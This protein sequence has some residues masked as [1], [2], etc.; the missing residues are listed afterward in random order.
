MT[1]NQKNQPE[2]DTDKQEQY[3][4][5][6]ESRVIDHIQSRTVKQHAAFF[7]S[8][9]QS[10]MSLLDCGC[11]PGTITLGLAKIVAPGHV[12]GIDLDKGQVNL[13]KAHAADQGISNISF[14]VANVYELPFEDSSFE[15]AFAHTLVQHLND[16][17]KGVKEIHRV[18]KPGGVMGI[19]DDDHG[20]MIRVPSN[21][22][23][24]QGYELFKRTWKHDGGDPLFGRRQREILRKAGFVNITATASCENYGTA[25]ATRSFGE[26]AAGFIDSFAKIAIQLGWTDKETIEQI[27]QEWRTWGENPDAF[28]MLPFCEAVGWKS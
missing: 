9:L 23:F 4:H 24:D 25:E 15:A 11:G 16:P 8:Y 21:P 27:K 26:T 2:I 13:A 10:G 7:R 6:Y 14:E 1:G 18:L 17:L 3:T 5:G 12:I 20:A 22:I 19:R 28:Y